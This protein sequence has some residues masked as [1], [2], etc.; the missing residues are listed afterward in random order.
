[1]PNF[2]EYRRKRSE[3]ERISGKENNSDNRQQQDGRR[4]NREVKYSVKQQPK[5]I[6]GRE[7]LTEIP[8]KKETKAEKSDR[9]AKA[10]EDAVNKG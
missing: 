8:K 5:V 6:A 1:M 4:D 3:N 10:K 2:R 9:R 7:I